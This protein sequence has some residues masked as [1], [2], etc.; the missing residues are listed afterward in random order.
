MRLTFPRLVSGFALLAVFSAPPALA[1]DAPAA[2]SARLAYPKAPRVNQVDDFFGR[3]GADPYRSLEDADPP[4]T[5]VDRRRERVTRAFL[6]AIP[7]RPR[8]A[9]ARGPLELR[10]LLRALPEGSRMFYRGTTA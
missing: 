5:R 2:A 6:D 9:R 4:A 10:A 3:N 1:L 8:S 7:Q